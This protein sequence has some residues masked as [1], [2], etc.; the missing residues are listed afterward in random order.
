MNSNLYINTD[1]AIPSGQNLVD[2]AAT[3]LTKLNNIYTLND[4]VKTSFLGSD[5]TKYTT[6]VEN[7]KDTMNNLQKALNKTG[8]YLIEVGN[9]YANARQANQDSIIG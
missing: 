3:L 7:M 2:H 1:I 8:N 4:S 5:S 6:A 9:A